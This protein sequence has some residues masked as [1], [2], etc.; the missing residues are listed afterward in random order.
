[1]KIPNWKS[2]AVNQRRTDNAMANRKITKGQT[3]IYK[4][5][6]KKPKIE[7]HKPY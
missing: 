3:V 5:L 2:E 1:L 6:Y 7:Q 4:A